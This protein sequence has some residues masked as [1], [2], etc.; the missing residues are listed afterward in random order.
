MAKALK[1]ATVDYSR[2]MGL[3]LRTMNNAANDPILR[4]NALCGFERAGT[5]TRWLRR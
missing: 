1:Q 5:Y 4:L 3:P 2:R